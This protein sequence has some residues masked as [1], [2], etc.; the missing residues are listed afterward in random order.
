MGGQKTGKTSAILAFNA[1]CQ[2]LGC[3]TYGS[4]DVF[5]RTKSLAPGI[6]DLSA[7]LK[8]KK[9]LFRE[10]TVDRKGVV[11]DFR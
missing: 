4:P 7:V 9:I 11:S 6:M 10:M 5:E 1:L 3:E 8:G 2:G